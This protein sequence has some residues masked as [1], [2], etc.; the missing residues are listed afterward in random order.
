MWAY[1]HPSQREGPALGA[2]R[3]LYA[4]VT[5]RMPQK[6][7]LDSGR[8]ETVG[9][10]VGLAPTPRRWSVCQPQVPFWHDPSWLTVQVLQ[11]TCRHCQKTRPYRGHLCLLLPEVRELAAVLLDWL[12]DHPAEADAV[13]GWVKGTTGA[14]P[15]HLPTVLTLLKRLSALGLSMQQ[16][17]EL[18]VNHLATANAEVER[19]GQGCCSALAWKGLAAVVARLGQERCTT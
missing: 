8:S 6:V 14:E 19:L 16:A 15:P 10:L 17:T 12:V 5:K 1:D 2:L 7:H 18:S 9:L 11:V 4:V 3:R 13:R